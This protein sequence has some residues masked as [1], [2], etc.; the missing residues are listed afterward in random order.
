INMSSGTATATLRKKT[1]RGDQKHYYFEVSAGD[2]GGAPVGGDEGAAVG[3]APWPG[4]P[5]PAADGPAPVAGPPAAPP[6]GGPGGGPRR[7]AAGERPELGRVT[8]DPGGPVVDLERG[9][10]HQGETLKNQGLTSK[11]WTWWTSS[12]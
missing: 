2:D 12:T 11:W 3:P 5:A 6:A 4:A 9:Q 10:V 1:I 8:V 7:R